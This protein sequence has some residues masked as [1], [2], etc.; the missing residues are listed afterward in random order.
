[1][2]PNQTNVNFFNN[3]LM[4]L[5]N[6]LFIIMIIKYC[7]GSD[8]LKIREQNFSRFDDETARASVRMSTSQLLHYSAL[9]VI[10]E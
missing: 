5:A 2:V 7:L 1:M 3:L 10:G 4:A 8:R 9:I 6:Q